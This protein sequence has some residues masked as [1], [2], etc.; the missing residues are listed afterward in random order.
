MNVEELKAAATTL[1]DTIEHMITTFEMTTGTTVA[2]VDLNR[3]A[4]TTVGSAHPQHILN[5]DLKVEI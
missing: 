5:V 4:V 1:S 2:T 3:I